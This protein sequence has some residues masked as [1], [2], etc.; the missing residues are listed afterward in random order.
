MQCNAEIRIQYSTNTTPYI[1]VRW[2]ITIRY[3]YNETHFKRSTRKTW[4]TSK[5]KKK[6]TIYHRCINITCKATAQILST[7]PTNSFNVCEVCLFEIPDFDKRAI[8][9]KNV[10]TN[11]LLSHYLHYYLLLPL[12][13]IQCILNIM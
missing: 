4:K 8:L 1:T 5:L 7:K 3:K 11:L 6:H 10:H 13:F 12:S 9:L 2:F